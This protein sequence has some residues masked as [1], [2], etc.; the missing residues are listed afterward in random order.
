M[1]KINLL[2]L[3]IIAIFSKSFA[4]S[5]YY[6]SKNTYGGGIIGNFVVLSSGN[7]GVE[8]YDGLHKLIAVTKPDN[9]EWFVN[10]SVGIIDRILKK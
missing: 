7:D 9:V 1:R 2:M 6:S 10:T 5:E 3:L 8:I 4:Q